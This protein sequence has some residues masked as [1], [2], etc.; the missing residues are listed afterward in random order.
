MLLHTRV[1]CY[2]TWGRN[3]VVWYMYG[4]VRE[5]ILLNLALMH[6]LSIVVVIA[7]FAGVAFCEARTT[8]LS[9]LLSLLGIAWAAATLRFDFLIHRQGAYLRQLESAHVQQGASMMWETWKQEHR[10]QNLALPIL[11]LLAALPIVAATAYLACRSARLYLTKCSIPGARAYPWV[12]MI[13]QMT[14]LALLAIIPV[15][16]GR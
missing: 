10:S 5:E 15:I 16:A 1:F 13:L 4:A 12:V 3:T 8:V 9:V 14:L 6:W 2:N 11:D 7:L